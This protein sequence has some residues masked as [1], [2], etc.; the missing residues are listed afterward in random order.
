MTHI[1]IGCDKIIGGRSAY[2]KKLSALEVTETSKDSLTDKKLGQWRT[3]SPKGFAFV[4]TAHSAM[5]HQSPKGTTFE[6]TLEGCPAESTG[7][8]QN[9][10]AVARAWKI[11]LEKARLLGSKIILLRTPLEF[12]PNEANRA[13]LA[14]FA[15]EMLGDAGKTAVAWEPH[16]LWDP[17]EYVP[18]ARELG[19]VPVFDPFLELPVK[20]GR[21]TAFFSLY[22]RR[23]LRTSFNDF[24]M[25]ELLEHCAPY[26]R[27]IVIFRG[28]KRFRDARLAQTIVESHRA[29][30]A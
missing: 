16:G 5:T 8:L 19:L 3:E 26:Q 2:F 4:T 28:P 25:E 18:L 20:Q 23:G 7:L 30:E 29:F 10:E 27:A 14:R 1:Y 24:D 17:E 13:N 9:T 11:S 12:S 21:G 15:K 22:T 6:G